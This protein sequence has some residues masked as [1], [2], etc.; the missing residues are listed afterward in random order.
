MFTT[1]RKTVVE[2]LCCLIPAHRTKLSVLHF[3]I[4]FVIYNK[5]KHTMN[6]HKTDK[7]IID[8]NDLI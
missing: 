4:S 1:T 8:K 5:N 7:N 6:T 2:K 3:E